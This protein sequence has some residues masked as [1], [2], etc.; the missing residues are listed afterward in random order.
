MI[1]TD[2][3]QHA[4]SRRYNMRDTLIKVTPQQLASPM[5]DKEICDPPKAKCKLNSQSTKQSRTSYA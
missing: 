3:T 1:W 2:L 5:Y 4:A